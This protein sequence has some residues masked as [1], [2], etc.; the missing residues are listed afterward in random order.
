ML[1]R[2]ITERKK[3]EAA[4]IASMQ[5]AEAALRAKRA[6]FQDITNTPADERETSIEHSDISV[7][8]MY[9]HLAGLMEEMDTRDI[10][11]AAGN[12]GFFIQDIT[13]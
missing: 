10:V 3:Q 8:D 12:A 9:D 1:T 11:L 7:A 13:T 4:F 6:L 5:R 2:D